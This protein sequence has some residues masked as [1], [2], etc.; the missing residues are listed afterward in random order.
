MACP[1][2]GPKKKRHIARRH[3]NNLDDLVKGRLVFW[4]QDVGRGGIRRCAYINSEF[5]ELKGVPIPKKY[6]RRF[7]FHRVISF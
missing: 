3:Y 1:A 6:G 4:H 5:I 7:L 2:C